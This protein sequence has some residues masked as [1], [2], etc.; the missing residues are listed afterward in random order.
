MCLWFVKDLS[1]VC[2]QVVIV[3]ISCLFKTKDV[4]NVMVEEIVLRNWGHKHL[5]SPNW[6]SKER[7]LCKFY[8]VI[9]SL[10][11]MFRTSE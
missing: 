2:L 9:K 5:A 11:L 6:I 7:M 3:L 10:G 1:L 8:H 4:V